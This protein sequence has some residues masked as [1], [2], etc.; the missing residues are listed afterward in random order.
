M[1]REMKNETEEMQS[2]GSPET[3][4]KKSGVIGAGK[5][6]DAGIKRSAGCRKKPKSQETQRGK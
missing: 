5:T 3:G 2:V 4:W 1:S 6:R